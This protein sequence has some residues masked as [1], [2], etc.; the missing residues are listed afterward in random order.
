MD[1]SRPIIAFL[2]L[3]APSCADA[4]TRSWLPGFTPRTVGPPAGFLSPEII[5]AD[6]EI[7][8]PVEEGTWRSGDQVIY[9][10]TMR[11]P[12]RFQ[13][14]LVRIKVHSYPAAG[15]LLGDRPDFVVPHSS[16]G[17]KVKN[18][19]PI[20]LLGVEI[21][22]ENGKAQHS[23]PVRAPADDL[24][25]GLYPG[26]LVGRR[27]AWTKRTVGD[28]VRVSFPSLT[29]EEIETIHR[30]L[31]TLNALFLL[32]S[33]ALKP[34][35]DTVVA[36]PSMMKILLH[37]GM[38]DLSI[39]AGMFDGAEPSLPFS[40]L[41]GQ[42]LSIP[43]AVRVYGSLALTGMLFVTDSRPPFLPGGGLVAIEAAHP[44]DPASTVSVRLLMAKRGPVPEL[45]R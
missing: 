23:A 30:S 17:Q 9:G 11:S 6:Q 10:I 4:P 19:S 13:Q 18:E 21:F 45:P 39:N 41:L 22:D 1:M 28:R 33:S 36:Q 16:D 42:V 27:A 2:I 8:I 25:L 7:E 20:V 40:G 35:V 15:D 38:I 43:F 32:S 24:D 12:S 3:A 5:G 14:W 26:C 37:G 44:E 29:G 31:A 34:I